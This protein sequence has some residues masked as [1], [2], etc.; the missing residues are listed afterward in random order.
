MLPARLGNRYLALGA[1]QREGFNILTRAQGGFVYVAV[2]DLNAQE[3]G[4]LLQLAAR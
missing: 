1:T 2:S 4:S 3:L